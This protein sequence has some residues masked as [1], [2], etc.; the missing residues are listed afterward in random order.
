MSKVNLIRKSKEGDETRK[1]NDQ[2]SRKFH[3]VLRRTTHLVSST[4]LYYP[5]KSRGKWRLKF[6]CYQG[7]ANAAQVRVLSFGGTS[8]AL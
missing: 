5:A 4:H 3:D 6:Q 7:P 1:S 2:K 8:T